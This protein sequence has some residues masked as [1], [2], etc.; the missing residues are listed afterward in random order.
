MAAR[1][2]ASDG[3]LADYSF[4]CV[5]QE[6]QR[7]QEEKLFLRATLKTCKLGIESGACSPNY[8]ETSKT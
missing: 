5:F 8:W 1:M 3:G 7:I 2:D 4:L 6:I